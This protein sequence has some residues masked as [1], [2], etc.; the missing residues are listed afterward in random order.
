MHPNDLTEQVFNE[1]F[2]LTFSD[3][4]PVKRVGKNAKNGFS[5]A[6][7][8][9]MCI[10][11]GKKGFECEWIDLNAAMPPCHVLINTPKAAVLVI[12]KGVSWFKSEADDLLLKLKS[13]QW[14]EQ[15]WLK[16]KLVKNPMRRHLKFGEK[17]YVSDEG[18]VVALKACPDIMKIRDSLNEMYSY[19]SV[20]F[21]VEGDH[22]Y[23]MERCGRDSFGDWDKRMLVGL[24]VGAT[25]KMAFTWWYQESKFSTPVEI[26]LHHGDIFVLSDKAVG[27]DIHRKAIATLKRTCGSQVK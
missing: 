3:A 20:N 9:K 26:E 16:H 8:R 6:E 19:R 7:L 13:L 11:F 24:Q 1:S 25:M 21:E 5:I 22:Y 15:V 27:H 2:T 12:R 23:D 17:Q 10:D 4:S 18:L 14:N